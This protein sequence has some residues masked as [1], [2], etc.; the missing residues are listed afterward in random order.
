MLY[1]HSSSSASYWHGAGRNTVTASLPYSNP[2]RVLTNAVTSS[3]LGMKLAHPCFVTTIA[4]QALPKRADRYQPQ[5]C[6]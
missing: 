2:P 3:I 1:L 4:P 6:T 5:P